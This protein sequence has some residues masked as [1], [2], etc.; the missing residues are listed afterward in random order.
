MI[1]L[2]RP[3]IVHDNILRRARKVLTKKE[4]SFTLI[5]GQRGCFPSKK[6]HVLI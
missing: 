5:S 2:L 6:E 1:A 3:V 4:T